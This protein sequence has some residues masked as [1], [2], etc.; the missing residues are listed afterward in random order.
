MDSAR[1]DIQRKANIRPEERGY[2]FTSYSDAPSGESPALTTH[3]ARSP[4][5]LAHARIHTPA[6]TVAEFT[7][8][9]ACPHGTSWTLS[10]DGFGAL[11]DPPPGTSV[12]AAAQA[13]N[14]GYGPTAKELKHNTLAFNVFV[15]L[16]VTRA[17]RDL[18][19]THT[20]T[21]QQRH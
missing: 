10:A 16:Q 9:A 5:A 17:R 7:P 2:V 8:F 20:H 14:H 21:Q 15:A 3:F 13:D 18:L 1:E 6:H 12:F 19:H 4:L 11:A